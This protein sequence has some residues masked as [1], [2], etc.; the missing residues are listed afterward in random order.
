MQDPKQ[1]VV[2]FYQRHPISTD[3]ILAKRTEERGNLENVRPEELYAHDQD[4]YGVLESNEA[5]AKRT[6]MGAG[7]KVTDFCA[8]LAG[9]GATG[10]PA[11]AST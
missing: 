2:E 7:K 9:P 10:P 1:H 4:H 3:H 5:L 8:G 11:T 6:G